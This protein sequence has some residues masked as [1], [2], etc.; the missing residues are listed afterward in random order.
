MSTGL[1]GWQGARAGFQP[2]ANW[3]GRL[4]A[5]YGARRVGLWAF[6][7]VVC[8]LFMLF[9][10][11]CVMR[12]GYDDWRALP[13]VPWQLWLSTAMLAA[14]DVAW[15]YAAFGARRG[16]RRLAL[17]AGTLGGLLALAFVASQLGA[18]RALAQQQV[19]ITASPAAG[20][21]YMLTG[22]HGVHV[23]GGLVAAICMLAGFVRH[24][25]LVRLAEGLG[26]CAQY[27]HLLL[28]LWLA[29]FGLL[30]GMSPELVRTLCAGVGITLR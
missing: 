6:M 28:A 5:P 22:L 14:G 11:A 29:L 18:W 8:V 16:R 19:A 30:F 2:D 27:W 23:M 24:R 26:L 12:I 7:G 9:T 1:P 20:F 21:F 4:P 10:A 25:S 15:Q 13:P 3:S 17:V